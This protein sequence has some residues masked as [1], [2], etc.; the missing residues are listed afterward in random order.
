MNKFEKVVR[1]RPKRKASGIDGL[2]RATNTTIRLLERSA[3]ANSI[4]A[5]DEK[6]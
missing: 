6:P 4:S 2:K 1:R 3:S 5:S